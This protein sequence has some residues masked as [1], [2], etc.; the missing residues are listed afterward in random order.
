MSMRFVTPAV[1]IV[2][3]GVASV[4][5]AEV[6]LRLRAPG[7][8]LVLEWTTDEPAAEYDVWTHDVPAWLPGEGVLLA[9]VAEPRHDVPIPPGF[10]AYRVFP[11]CDDDAREDDDDEASA[12]PVPTGW[13]T[14]SLVACH[15]DDDWFTVDVPADAW[16]QGWISWDGL[17]GLLSVEHRGITFPGRPDGRLYFSAGGPTEVTEA[18]RLWASSGAPV[19]YDITFLNQVGGCLPDPLEPDGTAAE[20]TPAFPERPFFAGSLCHPDVDWYEIQL[21]GGRRFEAQ[22]IIPFA[23]CEEPWL[24]LLAADGTTPLAEAQLDDPD[25]GCPFDLHRACLVYD[26]PSDGTYYLRVAN[27]AFSA[28]TEDLDADWYTLSMY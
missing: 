2:W 22:L 15:D 6:D 3:L 5:P 13:W 11:H 27:D 28:C 8:A 18:F 4:A 21:T 16:L 14:D 26:V 19:P 24:Q 23:M 1:A 9:T 7:G 10:A 17:E 25:S 12:T 20:A